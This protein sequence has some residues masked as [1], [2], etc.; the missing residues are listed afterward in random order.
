MYLIADDLIR[1]TAEV[2]QA[3]GLPV[4]DRR[5]VESCNVTAPVTF[6]DDC[7][8]QLTVH[9]G[10]LTKAAAVIG[11]DRQNQGCNM[12][13][14][15]PFV[16]TLLR[17][18]PIQEEDPGP[19]ALDAESRKHLRDGWALASGLVRRWHANTLAPNAHLG[20]CQ[21]VRWGNVTCIAPRGG[22]LGWTLTVTIPL[23]D[24]ANDTPDA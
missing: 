4:P 8:Q 23:M 5:Y 2:L 12:V 14:E 7:A 20:D 9:V 13:W 21:Y 11:N 19:D 22:I 10:S 6:G 15:A 24:A 18:Y 17:C 1:T 16:V 3:A